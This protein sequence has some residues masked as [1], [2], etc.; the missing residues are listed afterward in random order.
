MGRL[1]GVDAARLRGLLADGCIPVLAPIALERPAQPLN[2][3][4][5]TVAGEVARALG[6]A[7]LIFLTAVD[8]VLDERGALLPQLGAERAAALREAGTLAGG[9]L[10]KVDAS[11]RAAGGGSTAVIANG[12]RR[13]TVREIVS[14]ARVGTRLGG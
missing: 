2:V 6:A 8:G 7:L 5:D 14:G 1:T 13:G 10:P 11:L 9:M 4:A 12:R 3:N